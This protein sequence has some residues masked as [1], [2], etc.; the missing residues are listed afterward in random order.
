MANLERRLFYEQ[1]IDQSPPDPV[2]R[3]DLYDFTTI[4]CYTAAQLEQIAII[5]SKALMN[6]SNTDAS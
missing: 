6:N 4:S 5:F 2:H 3:E 1:E